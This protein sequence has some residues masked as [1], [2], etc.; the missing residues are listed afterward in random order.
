MGI[1]A[2]DRGLQILDYVIAQHR[3]CKYSEIRGALDRV[4]DASLNRLLRSLLESGHL[5]KTT[6]GQY[7]LTAK[8]RH[9]AQLVACSQRVEEIIELHLA[10]LSRRTEEAAAFC[11]LEGDRIE[12]VSSIQC[13]DSIRIVGPGTLL[14]YESDHAAVLSIFELMADESEI[15]ACISSELSKTK[16]YEEYVKDRVEFQEGTLFADRSRRRFGVTRCSA[17][18]RCKGNPGA[19]FICLPT[20]RYERDRVRLLAQVSK[21]AER[22]QADLDR[23][24]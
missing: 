14:H 17:G 19:L 7:A 9:W 24:Q 23:M 20:L 21:S 16:S 12:T 5:E 6:D 10:E 18:V 8:V 3:P 11:L 4:G 1:P 15:R 22:L 2:L 13:V